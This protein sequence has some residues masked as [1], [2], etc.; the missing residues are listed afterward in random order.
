M[1][2]GQ[3]A[4]PP[5]D[6]AA[7]AAEIAA[8]REEYEALLTRPEGWLSLVGLHWLKE[9]ANACGGDPASAVPLPRAPER[10]GTFYLEGGEVSF[11]ALPEAGITVS[12]EPLAGRV[13]LAT[14]AAGEPTILELGSLRFYVIARADAEHGTRYGVRIKDRQ[15]PRIA[16]FAG[17]DAYPP[18]PAWRVASRFVP[19]RPP[20]TIPVPTV[21]GTV[22]EMESPGALEFVAGGERARLD[23]LDGGE[24]ELWL[25]FADQTNGRETY[26]GGRFLYVP[27]PDDRGVVVIDFN[28]AYNP[29]CAYT[30]FA[31]CP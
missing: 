29:P 6:A 20:K 26:G 28:K 24:D 30:P 19:Y 15:S 12:G 18:D 16:A 17:I 21:L 22:V 3:V 5:V 7:Y 9:G 27:R 11:E 10:A 8:W 23:A 2:G 14:D 1:E 4:P 25:I 13:V 31:T